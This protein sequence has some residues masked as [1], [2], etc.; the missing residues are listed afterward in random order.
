MEIEFGA[1]SDVGRMRQNNEDAF[2]VA[3]EIGLFVLSDGMG[4]QSSGEVAS[5]LASETVVA[6][7]REASRNPSLPLV[8]ERAEGISEAGNRLASAIRLANRA[9]HQ[10]AQGNA[11]Q[12]GMGATLVAV[13][14]TEERVNIAHV[15]DSRVYR[16]RNGE[17]E[18]LTRDHSFIAEQVRQGLMTEQ[19]ANNSN[20]Q[21][22]LLRA[23]GVDAEVEVEVNEELLAEEDA[24]LLCS[25][26]LT[27]ELSDA[28]IAK[29]LA[30][31]DDPQAAA[32]RLIKL[33]NDA[34]GSDNISVI[35][36]RNAPRLVGTFEK[37]GRWFKGC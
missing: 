20:L 2:R 5:R 14:L 3:P 9:V 27:K 36:L 37:L 30:E 1:R 6:H 17:L 7:C 33:A 34:G 25:D 35:V 28:E 8:G 26:G 29:V 22:V 19:E 31:I 21:N 24:L 10:A 12:A 23:V 32:D 13:V 15:G 11:A 16:L 4:G 18:S